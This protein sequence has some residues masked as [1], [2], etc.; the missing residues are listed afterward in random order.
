MQSQFKALNTKVYE[1]ERSRGD[2]RQ[3]I[4]DL[5]KAAEVSAKNEAAFDELLQQERDAL[6]QQTSDL[7]VQCDEAQK[8]CRE[9]E[10]N[11]VCVCMYVCVCVC[12]LALLFTLFSVPS[13]Y[14]P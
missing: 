1:A 14:L 11:Q 6:N 4:M 13:Y 7:R 3:K 12:G 2:D 5:T 8:K 10:E 9:L